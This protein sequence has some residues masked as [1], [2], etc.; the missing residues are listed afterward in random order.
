MISYKG[1]QI[2]QT[3][4][5][6]V[7]PRHT[8]LIVHE[9]LND[10]CGKGGAFDK[11]GR[12]IDVSGILAGVQALIAEAR[13]LKIKL[14]Y[15]RYTNHADYSTLSDPMIVRQYD[16]IT[17]PNSPPPASVEGTWGWENLDE[18]KPQPGDTIVKKYRVDSFLGTNLD[19]ILRWNAHPD[20]RDPGGRRR[21]RDRPHRDARLQPGL[22]RGRGRRLHPPHRAG[23]AGRRHEVHRPL[24]DGEVSPRDHPGLAIEVAGLTGA[25]SGQS[26]SRTSYDSSFSP[27]NSDGV[28]SRARWATR[29]WRL[30]M[31]S[32]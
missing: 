20:D 16:T 8:V 25:G 9:L 28:P 23:L 6:I 31:K 22:L 13:R 21:G 10:F 30:F 17:N 14:V 4:E 24:G 19:H 12:I 1:R 5:E 26:D 29:S 27:L 2:P 3:F 11:A 15:V 18:V 32:W 7:D